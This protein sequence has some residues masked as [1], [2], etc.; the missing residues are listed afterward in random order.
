[1]VQPPT[2]PNRQQRRSNTVAK[3]T[4]DDFSAKTGAKINIVTVPDPYEQSVQ[5][6]VAS[7]DKPDL[8]FWQPTASELTA[9]NAKTNLQTLD[10]AP[11]I[12]KYKPALKDVTGILDG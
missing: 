11:F 12:A 8:A 10:G 3:K 2:S 9:I 5:T 4:A 6:K 7:G 1:L